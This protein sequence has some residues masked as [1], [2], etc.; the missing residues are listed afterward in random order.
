MT[1][2]EN[3]FNNLGPKEWLPFQ[4]SFTIYDTM[5]LLIE[6][7]LRFFTKPSVR[8]KPNVLAFGSTDFLSTFSACAK[9]LKIEQNSKSNK[10]DFL[11]VNLTSENIQLSEAMDWMIDKSIHLNHRKFLWIIIPTNKLCENGFP[12]AWHLSNEL[13]TYLTRKDEKIICLPDGK[14]WTSLYFRKDEHSKLISPD[15]NP[16]PSPNPNPNPNL[17]LDLNPTS[18]NDW[19]IL[20]PKPRSKNEILH[21]AKYP[22]D[23][24]KLYLNEYT[25][26]GD[27]VFD[28]MSGTGTTQVTALQLNRNAYGIE[29]SE[30]FHSIAT[31]RCESI[32]SK[33]DW[34]IFHGDARNFDTFSIPNLDYVITS[35][36]YWDMLNMKGA[37]IQ[38]ARKAKG[39]QT[40]YSDHE[41]DLG[42]MTNYSEFLKLLLDIYQ[43]IIKKLK[44][45][46]HFTIIV[47]NI[48]KKGQHYPLAFDLCGKL[49][50]E[51]ELS[52]I[53]F[54]CQDDLQIA[55]YGYKHTWVSNTFH[56]YC[57]TFKKT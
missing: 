26:P 24:V 56:H 35:P 17:D 40:N 51:M 28:P 21:P 36:P 32:Q 20:K 49:I 41:N 6:S 42:N 8:P 13:S 43:S 45:G 9:Q 22:E 2:I 39:L 18:F 3:K 50:P 57:L 19:F 30:L 46:G 7:N 1:K 15:P 11:A 14:T 44:K 5:D 12:L 33:N 55:P 38:A 25:Q 27:T 54:W 52:H 4:K 31:N 37:E 48:K 10:F 47:K 29:L 16:N 53:G 34:S 23:L